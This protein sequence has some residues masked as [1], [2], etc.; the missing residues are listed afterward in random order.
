MRVICNFFFLVSRVK[1]IETGTGTCVFVCV[2][3]GCN[4]RTSLIL[5]IAPR[6]INILCSL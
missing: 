2:G 3:G 5:L 6:I 1:T 4:A